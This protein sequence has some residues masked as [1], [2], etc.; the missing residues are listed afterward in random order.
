M[1]DV[2]HSEEMHMVDE[3]IIGSTVV[4]DQIVNNKIFINETVC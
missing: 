2:K 4:K 1:G 3:N